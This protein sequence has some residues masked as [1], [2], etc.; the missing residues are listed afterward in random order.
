M[1]KAIPFLITALVLATQAAFAQ[2]PPVSTTTVAASAPG[3]AAVVTKSEITA[4]VVG[5]DK[6]TRTVTLKGPK[7]NT[8]DIVAG[9]EVK[10]FDQIKIGDTV[11]AQFVEALT[12]ELKKTKTTAGAPTETVAVARAQPGERPAGMVGRE[13]TALAEVVAVDPKKS[14]ITLKGP[15]GN[16]IDLDVRNP[17]QFKVV[18]VGDQ[19]EVVYTE[20]LAMA[21]TPAPKAAAKK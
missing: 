20:A 4:T 18:K 10:N 11:V 3:K 19:V 9:D 14:T 16:K 13:V 1:R 15:R 8:K 5:I 12:L 7:G 17:E 2:T 6:T 21:V